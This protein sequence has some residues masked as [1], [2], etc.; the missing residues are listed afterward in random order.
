MY[1]VKSFSDVQW[2]KTMVIFVI[3]FICVNLFILVIQE[4]VVKEDESQRPYKRFY[5]IVLHP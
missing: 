2:Y 1:N 5:K 3:T 4:E